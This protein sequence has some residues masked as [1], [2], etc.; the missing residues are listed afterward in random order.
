YRV[1]P[2]PPQSPDLNVI[3]NVEKKVYKYPQALY[4]G[5]LWTAC[6]EEWDAIEQDKINVLIKTMPQCIDDIID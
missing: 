5:E 3:K 6:E 2:W 1:V 4:G